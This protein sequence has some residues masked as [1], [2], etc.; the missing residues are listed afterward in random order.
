[1]GLFIQNIRVTLLDTFLLALLTMQFPGAPSE[2]VGTPMTALNAISSLDWFTPDTRY[3]LPCETCVSCVVC[4][5]PT[6]QRICVVCVSHPQRTCVTPSKNVCHTLEERVSH[7]Q[8]TCV[9]INI[10]D[11]MRCPEHII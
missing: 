9:T 10:V 8:R 11:S 5:R 1:M 2:W 7:P 3:H 4:D 6:S